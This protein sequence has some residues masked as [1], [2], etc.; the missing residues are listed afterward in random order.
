[1][2]FKGS[3]RA[4]ELGTDNSYTP[5]T[6][7]RGCRQAGVFVCNP[8]LLWQAICAPTAT[9]WAEFIASQ[10]YSAGPQCHAMRRLTSASLF[11]RTQNF[12]TPKMIFTLA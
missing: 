2:A 11:V 4:S 8:P 7:G 3:S 12:Q 9:V 10:I 5:I 1:M 6:I